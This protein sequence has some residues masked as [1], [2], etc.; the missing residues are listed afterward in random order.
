MGGTGSSSSVM[1]GL[2]IWNTF[3]A[4][5]DIITN[6]RNTKTVRKKLKLIDGPR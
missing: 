5:L 2:V 4:S 1:V 3:I 6:I